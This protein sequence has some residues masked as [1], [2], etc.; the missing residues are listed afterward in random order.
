L[1]GTSFDGKGIWLP[2][3]MS[4]SSQIIVDRKEWGVRIPRRWV[5][6][7]DPVVMELQVR[8]AIPSYMKGSKS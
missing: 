8:N 4:L 6:V 7:C 2:E 5:T 1:A 3:L